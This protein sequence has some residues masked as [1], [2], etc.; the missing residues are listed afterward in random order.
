MKRWPIAMAT[1]VL[2]AAACTAGDSQT[3]TTVRRRYGQ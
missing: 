3:R 1:F 2:V